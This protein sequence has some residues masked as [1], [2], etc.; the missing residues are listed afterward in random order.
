MSN[1]ANAVSETPRE[2]LA[3]IIRERGFRKGF[4]AERASISQSA[5][6]DILA[7]RRKF[8]A[9]YAVQLAR[10]LDVP[11]ETFVEAA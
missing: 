10:A 4:V 1:T 8:S 6:S 7:G 5:L 11:I 3:R 9:Y 2:A